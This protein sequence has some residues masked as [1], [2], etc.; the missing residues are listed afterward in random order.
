MIK[1]L[2]SN[3]YNENEFIN[4]LD[5]IY[6][7]GNTNL[8]HRPKIGIVGSRHPNDYA[9]QLI[10]QISNKL[11]NTGICIVSGGAMGID[12]ISH[13]NAGTTNTIMVAGTGLDK[14]YPKINSQLIEDIEN[15]GLVI[16]Q[17]EAGMPSLP[18]N[19]AIRNKIIVELS[20]ILIVAYADKNS[21][22]MRSINYA[23]KN[24]TD[25]YVLP[26]RL[27][28]SDG[29]NDLLQRGLATAIYD[30]DKFVSKFSKI[31]KDD[32]T[33]DGLLQYCQ[34]NPVY[35]EAISQY[36]AK[37]F[38]YELQ[39]KIYVKNGIINIQ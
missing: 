39:G 1:K 5:S 11:S 32:G 23:L 37:I 22:T 27:G 29:T 34:T 19:F 8:L 3:I 6:Y 33:I 25:V 26:H 17:F 30:V 21:G 4:N 13:K 18:R 31:Q 7:I 28:Q 24:D 35:D 20:K 14:R 9:K 10:G 12:A 36:G 16:S 2:D 38:E 15:N